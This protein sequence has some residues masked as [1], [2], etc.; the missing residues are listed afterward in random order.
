MEIIPFKEIEVLGNPLDTENR[1]VNF[2][3]KHKG[4]LFRLIINSCVE[5]NRWFGIKEFV[6]GK[7]FGELMRRKYIPRHEITSLKLEGYLDGDIYRILDEVFCFSD[8]HRT[9]GQKLDCLKLICNIQIL[10]EEIGSGYCLTDVHHLQFGFNYSFPV[11]I[12]IGSF[13]ENRKVGMLVE[14]FNKMLFPFGLKFDGD[15]GRLLTEIENYQITL[16]KGEWGEY[17]NT[18]LFEE[19][20]MAHD[21]VK[22][23]AHNKTFMDVGCNTGGAAKF[24]NNRGYNVIA[25]D[26]E[27]Y[28]LNMLYKD[29][30]GRKVFCLKA[31]LTENYDLRKKEISADVV[32]CSSV[33]HHLCRKG[34]YF[35]KQAA[36][37]NIF[38]KKF[39]IVEYIDVIDFHVSQWTEIDGR[40]SRK[41]FLNSLKAEWE[42][43]KMLPENERER[44]WYFLQKRG[45]NG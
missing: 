28:A 43:I 42:V 13:C 20:T 1:D 22:E 37:W 18:A 38:C 8:E 14:H 6:K 12:D 11:Y 27:E 23:K 45:S 16:G 32:F 39:L 9:I 17:T 34:F 31:D 10:L 21:F 4:L 19:C 41:K 44:N 35:D 33:T 30:A 2:V 3:F 7:E 26:Y 40:Y 24:F 29:S 25:I 15:W 36:L 5:E